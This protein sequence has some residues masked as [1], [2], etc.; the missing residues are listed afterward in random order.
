MPLELNYFSPKTHPVL[1]FMNSHI[2]LNS[3]SGGG[4]KVWPEDNISHDTDWGSN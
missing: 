1:G 2:S 4:D 3:E